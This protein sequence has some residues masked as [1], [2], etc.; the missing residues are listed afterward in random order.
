V[1]EESDGLNDV[2][3]AAAQLDTVNPDHKLPNIFGSTIYRDSEDQSLY[4]RVLSW[5][6]DCGWGWF[7]VYLANDM[8]R[9]GLAALRGN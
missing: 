8:N 9:N 6:A 2:P 5:N 4:G 7:Y 3:D 1:S